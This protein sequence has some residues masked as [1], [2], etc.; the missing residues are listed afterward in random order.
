MERWRSK[1]APKYEPDQTPVEI[2]VQLENESLE[3]IMG[4]LLGKHMADRAMEEGYDSWEDEND[5]EDPN[6]E[7]LL[8]MTPYEFDELD[9]DTITDPNAPV[10]PVQAEGAEPTPTED[11]APEAQEGA[12][13]P[14]EEAL[15]EA[16]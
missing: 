3:S 7:R 2:P 8:D 9:G 15:R 13:A 5:F 12:S 14:A 10:E 6:P 11:S 16:E 1:Q 4:R